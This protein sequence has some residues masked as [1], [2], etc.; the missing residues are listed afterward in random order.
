MEHG[1]FCLVR[2]IQSVMLSKL[3]AK[4]G[5]TFS[6]TN[7]PAVCNLEA[8]WLVT[9]LQTC[10]RR[11]SPPHLAFLGPSLHQDIR[12]HFFPSTHY[13]HLQVQLP[14]IAMWCTDDSHNMQL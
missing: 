5:F 8:H 3:Q 7:D 14:L 12:D 2:S 11:Q 9:A 13:P 1:A 4:N 10:V 6:S